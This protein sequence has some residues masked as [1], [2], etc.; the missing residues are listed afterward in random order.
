MSPL[1]GSDGVTIV[2][3]FGKAPEDILKGLLDA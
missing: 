2:I 3:V 1:L